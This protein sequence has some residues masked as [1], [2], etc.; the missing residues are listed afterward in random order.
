MKRFFLF[1]LSVVLGAAMLVAAQQSPPAIGKPREQSPDTGLPLNFERHTGDLDAMVEAQNIRALVLYGL[2]SFF[3]VNGRP[4]GINY[5]A[6]QDFERF[7]NQKL[8]TG[9]RHVQVTFIPVRPDQL[10]PYLNE[11]IGDL[12]A[13]PV[14]ETPEREQ[15]VAFSVPVETGMKQILVTGKDFGPVASLQDLSGKKVFVNPLTTY[16]G[17]LEKVNDS[18]RKQDKPPIRIESADKNLLDEDLM[19]I[20]NA[21]ILPATVTITQRAKL[22]ASVFHN[23]TPQPSIVIANQ[24]DLAWAV[25]KNNPKFKELVDE[26]V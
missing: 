9:R 21:G 3:Y 26:F 2:S 19:E 11:G 20:V 6:L 23:I 7:V 17:N 13:F 15:Q 25:R 10:E 4:Q 5:E 22:W 16:Y 8:D 18:L 14:A 12:V 1:S 24:Q